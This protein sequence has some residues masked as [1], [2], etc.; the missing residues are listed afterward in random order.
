MDPHAT[1]RIHSNSPY[2][3]SHM[4]TS[5]QKTSSK[6]VLAPISAVL[7]TQADS[8]SSASLLVPAPDFIEGVGMKKQP[9]GK[10][11]IVTSTL[12]S[13]K[14]GRPAL[15]EA[16]DAERKHQR[17]QS[18]QVYLTPNVSRLRKLGS[19]MQLNEE[20]KVSDTFFPSQPEDQASND[21]QVSR[22]LRARR[23]KSSLGDTS[24]RPQEPK[25]MS[26]GHR[27]NAQILLT[28]VS[29][30]K[31]P[32]DYQMEDQPPRPSLIQLLPL[33]SFRE[34]N[35]PEEQKQVVGYSV[36][37]SSANNKWM[38]VSSKNKPK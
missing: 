9:S 6:G 28:A 19:E 24:D 8:G 23:F 34:P 10:K 21:Y 30:E 3:A 15:R 4:A 5:R 31:P 20:Q 22:P 35:A 27:K 16:P 26:R 32:S 17:Q 37:R 29:Q 7:H 33:E 25:T 14:S 13:S 12:V 18:H 38:L 11:I 2:I 36:K 1:P